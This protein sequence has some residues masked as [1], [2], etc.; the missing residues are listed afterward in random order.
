[1]GKVF[2]ACVL[3]LGAAF[4]QSLREG[5]VSGFKYCPTPTNGRIVSANGAWTSNG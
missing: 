2:V 1:M 4:G 5:S 3:L